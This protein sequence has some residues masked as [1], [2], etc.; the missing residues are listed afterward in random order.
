MV[1]VEKIGDCYPSVLQPERQ[2]TGIWHWIG[3]TASSLALIS[4]LTGSYIDHGNSN[5]LIRM[6]PNVGLSLGSEYSKVMIS[7]LKI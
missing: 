2:E 1:C 4:W 6:Y 3:W 5:L 7:L